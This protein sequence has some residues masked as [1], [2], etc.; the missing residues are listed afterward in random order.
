MPNIELADYGTIAQFGTREE[1]NAKL[2]LMGQTLDDVVDYVD[3]YGVSLL[4][5]CLSSRKID[6]AKELLEKNAKVN[7]VSK[8]GNNEFHLLAAN[9]RE[10]GALDVAWMLLDR[11]VSLTE[12]DKKYKNTA[13]FT[14][15][16]EQLKMRTPESMDFIEACLK[17]VEKFAFDIPN[18]AG[19]TLRGFISENG[20]ERFKIIMEEKEHET[21]H[22][23][24]WFHCFKKYLGK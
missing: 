21:E 14:L 4:G 16:L 1:F 11:G 24:G 22:G 2:R 17:K 5:R 13:L 19:I 23:H 10:E 6:F 20:P 12:Q 3:E 9:I 18:K 8:E 7:V 15:Y